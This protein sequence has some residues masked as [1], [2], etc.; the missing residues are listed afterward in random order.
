[1]QSA[2]RAWAEIDLAAFRR[3]LKRA[4]QRAGSAEVWPVLKANAYGHG[5]VAIARVCSE[6]KVERIGVGDSGEALQLR[7]SGVK[8]P[9]L[10]LGTIIDAEV[11]DLLA[12]DVEVGV[13][14]ESRVRKLGAIAREH[15]TQLAV[16]L[17]VDTGLGR[18]GVRPEV[19]LRV[20]QAIEDEPHLKFRGLMTHFSSSQGAHS[21]IT[22]GQQALFLAAADE[23]REALGGLPTL[24]CANSAA[25]F[26]GLNPITDAVRPG[27]SLFG[28]LPAD[29]CPDALLEPVLSLYTQLVFIKDVP[30]GT[31]VG[32]DGR[33]TS[34]QATRL[35]TLPMGY[36]DGLP[37]RVGKGGR[38]QVLVRGQRCPIVGAVSMD[39]CTI[40]VTHVQDATIGDCVTIIGKDG[41][42]VLTAT[43]VAN[44]AGTIP[45]EITCRLGSRVKRIYRDLQTNDYSSHS[46]HSKT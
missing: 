33:W 15:G 20:A 46:M 32:Y 1:M 19:A 30:A 22:E 5:A 31:Q 36:N 8:L 2:H 26:S 28:I 37:F 6:E 3:N 29:V 9:L 27:I 21:T 42:E 45:Y 24:H 16:H 14:S 35:A 23:I 13:H 7:H 43:H 41:L 34:H 38:G 11:K 4:R 18:L 17:K 44:A 12:H 25:L 10:V 39:Y 40:D